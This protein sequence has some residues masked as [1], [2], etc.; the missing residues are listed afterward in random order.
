MLRRTSVLL[1]GVLLALF[2]ATLPADKPGDKPADKAPAGTWK[3]TAAEKG[4]TPLWLIHLESRDGKWTGKVLAT[5]EELPKSEMTTVVVKDGTLRFTIKVA[6]SRINF[7]GKIPAADSDKILGTANLPRRVDGRVRDVLAPV[8]LV[9]TTLTGLD[10]ESLLKDVVARSK[11]NI[12]VVGA[13]ERLLTNAGFR[14]AKP[15]EV[16]GWMDRALKAAEPYGPR[17]QQEVLLNLVKTLNEQDGMAQVAL[18][19]ARRAER[20]LKPKDRPELHQ[21]T[22]EL[23]ATALDRAG[24]ADEAKDVTARIAKIDH[25]VRVEPYPPRTD[26]TKRVAVVELFTGTECPP[27]VAADLAFDAL[28]KAFQPTEAILLEYHEHIPGP[29]PLT[30]AQTQARMKYYAE[31]Y[32]GQVRGTPSTLFNGT[33]SAGGGGGRSAAQGKYDQYHNAVVGQLDQPAGLTL[34]AK[35]TRTG[36][37]VEVKA[38]VDEL[39]DPGMSV[40]LRLVLV[41]DTVSYKGGNGI[42]EHHHVVRAFP[43]GLEGLPLKAKAAKHSATVD[44]FELK[45]E[46]EKG[47][48]EDYKKAEEMLP[49]EIPME[50]KNLHVVALVQD[51]NS[52]EILHAIQVPVERSK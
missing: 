9:R 36:D 29:D 51:D 37:K 7:E 46:L 4:E 48:K 42:E 50:F 10:K 6:D 13:V 5:A 44:L 27:C 15:E 22:L 26:K 39:K 20:L 34:K 23:L 30:N 19:Y 25:S 17:Y 16:R 40:R 2:V 14:R 28:G 8:D 41:E 31:A 52:R 18:P 49:K 43:G 1:A 38:E 35:A 47:L 11:D 33:P 3:F 21:R 12:T 45:K 24:K 32:A